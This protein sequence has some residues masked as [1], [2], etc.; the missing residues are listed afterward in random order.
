MRIDGRKSYQKIADTSGN[1]WYISKCTKRKGWDFGVNGTSHHYFKENKREVI[2]T[3]LI[4][5]Q[6]FGRIK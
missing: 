6:E 2:T 5:S 3:I 1:H 4:T